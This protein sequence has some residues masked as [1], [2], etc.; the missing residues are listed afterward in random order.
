MEDPA[1]SDFIHDKFSLEEDYPEWIMDFEASDAPM[2]WGMPSKSIHPVYF[3]E[4]VP[5]L[6]TKLLFRGEDD[7]VNNL[8]WKGVE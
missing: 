1:I 6:P 2:D 7:N 4:C 8:V 3:S 5:R